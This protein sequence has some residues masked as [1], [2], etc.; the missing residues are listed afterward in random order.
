M[1]DDPKELFP[2]LEAEGEDAI[3]EKLAQGV[4]GERRIPLVKEWLEQKSRT[5]SAAYNQRLEDRLSTKIDL[6]S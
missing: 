4:Y 6:A 1:A 5:R 3:R 2:K